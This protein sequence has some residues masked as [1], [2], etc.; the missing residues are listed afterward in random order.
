MHN[1]D[2]NKAKWQQ[3]NDVLI[4]NKR[5]MKHKYLTKKDYLIKFLLGIC[6]I[7]SNT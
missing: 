7:D 1:S 6:M 5:A 2:E 4:I 3:N